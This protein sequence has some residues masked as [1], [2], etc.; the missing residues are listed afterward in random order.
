MIFFEPN[1]WYTYAL[2]NHDENV[3]YFGIHH[4]KTYGGDYIHSSVNEELRN[5][6]VNQKI[7]PYVVFKGDGSKLSEEK[8]HALETHLINLAKKLQI[9]CYNGNSGGGFQGGARLNILEPKDLQIGEDIL[10]NQKY[11]ENESFDEEEVNETMFRISEQVRLAVTQFWNKQEGRLYNIEREVHWIPV[12]DALNISFVQIRDV[13]VDQDNVQDIIE[14]IMTDKKNAKYEIEAVTIV[15]MFDKLMRIDGTST[16]NAIYSLDI[17]DREN[18]LGG[19]VPVVYI[20]YS[21]FAFKFFNMK[22]YGNLRNRPIKVKKSNNRNSLKKLI[23]E[24]HELPEYSVLFEYDKTSFVKKFIALNRKSYSDR[25]MKDALKKYIEDYE[26]E[27]AMGDNWIS[28]SESMKSDIEGYLAKKFK[29]TQTT[30]VTFSS[31]QNQSVGNCANLFGNGSGNKTSVVVGY[32]SIPK[33][34]GQ[35]EALFNK[36]VNSLYSMCFE[37]DSSNDTDNAIAF[38]NPY[39]KTKIYFV[40]LP[41]RYDTSQFGSVTQNIINS[42]FEERNESIAA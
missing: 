40:A 39:R 23:E 38:C 29:T 24:F 3:I 22:I 8:A 4:Q 41:C 15:R 32:H 10:F 21:E 26:I 7:T 16:C 9:D 1:K 28:Y 20:D 34:E 13:T 35:H 17:E 6:I 27:V 37:R 11:P 36:M 12:E 18:V 33:T 25:R 30:L 31:L 5:D 42:L 14:H 2:V 19:K